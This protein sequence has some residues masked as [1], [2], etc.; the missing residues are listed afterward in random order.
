LH[1]LD[2]VSDRHAHETDREHRLLVEG[3]VRSLPRRQREVVV[4][5][6]L[7]DLSVEQTAR[8]LGLRPGSVKAHLAAARTNLRTE[9]ENL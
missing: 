7:A 5:F 2:D 1:L 4:L 3:V 8:A 6:Y 9:M